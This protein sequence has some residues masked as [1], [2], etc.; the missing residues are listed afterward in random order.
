MK[1]AAL[2]LAGLSL[3]GLPGSPAVAASMKPAAAETLRVYNAEDYRLAYDTFLGSQDRE[4]AYQV[5]S[6]AVASQPLDVDWRRRLARVAEWTQRPQ[7]AW[8]NWSYLYQQGDR[9]SEVVA[10]VLRLTPLAADTPLMLEL[11]QQRM[12]DM[13]DHRAWSAAEQQELFDLYETLGQAS[14]GSRYFEAQ[15]RRRGQLE[16]LER[17]AQLADRVGEDE[18]ALALYRERLQQPPLALEACLRAS[19]FLLRR[20]RAREA[21]A[22]LASQRGQVARAEAAD[23]KARGDAAD[24]WQL[25]MNLAF[26]LTDLKTAET[27]LRRLETTAESSATTKHVSE[28]LQLVYMLSPEQPAQAAELAQEAYRRLAANEAASALFMAAFGYYVDG[29]QVRPARRLLDSLSPVALQQLETQAPFLRLRARLLQLQ[30]RTDLAWQDL[31]RARQLA[32]QDDAVLLAVFWFLIDQQRWTELP[33]LLQRY[34]VQAKDK[35]DYWL[36]YA[37]AYHGL[38]DYKRAL[39]WYRKAIKHHPDDSLLLLNYADALERV[40]QSGMAARVR[41]HAWLKLRARFAGKEVQAP[42]DAQPELLAYARLRLQDAAADEGGRWVRQVVAQLRRLPVLPA[43]A[44]VSAA[45]QRAENATLADNEAAAIRLQDQQTRDLILAWAIGRGLAPQARAWMWRSQLQRLSPTDGQPAH[46]DS[47]YKAPLWGQAQTSLQLADREWMGQLL[48]GGQERQE[49]KLPAYNRYDMAHELGHGQ[50]AL[51]TAFRGLDL[52]GLDEELHDRYR[53]HVPDASHYVQLGA[54]RADYG[55]LASRQ[56]ELTVHL[57]VASRLQLDMGWQQAHQSSADVNL[58]APSHDR[59][60]RTRLGWQL[61]RGS[62][63]L[64][65]GRH[66]EMHT[67]TSWRLAQDWTWDSRLQFQAALARNIE[68]SESQPLRIAGSQDQVQLGAQYRLGRREYLALNQEWS[69]YQTQYDSHL[70]S[71]Q[72]TTLEAGYRFRLEYPDWRA[73]AYVSNQRYSAHGMVDAVTLSR[74]AANVQALIANGELDVVRYFLPQDSTTLGACVGMGENLGGQNLQ[75][76][77]SRAWRHFYDL[78]ATHDSVNGGGYYGIIG[79]A[80]S[81][82]GEDHLSL[83]LEQGNGGSGE[84]SLS[85]LLSARYRHYF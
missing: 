85:R 5:A 77:Y 72:R 21:Y 52:N 11:W 66:G 12:A 28:W 74:L 84:G 36:A 43:L 33:A 35:P 54:A 65:L 47:D 50:L 10:A 34:A 71:G 83:R 46:A 41:R 59:L 55:R 82:A 32:P 67:Q 13:A 42:F 15:Y 38:D 61:D 63:S 9:S 39:E 57:Q 16:L 24:Y 56:N 49:L 53:Q 2:I 45:G 22:L 19:T 51:D 8:R 14:A 73:R 30:N 27:A 70:G 62:V 58:S 26:Q 64:E 20:D 75:T 31:Q 23:G 60:V 76:T 40:Q 7:I 37:A 68:A 48:K 4:R 78:C 80:G 6:A 25:L 44:A 18:R 3:A 1:P 81:I 79:V 17:A 29:H 69:R